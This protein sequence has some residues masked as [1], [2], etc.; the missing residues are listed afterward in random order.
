MKFKATLDRYLAKVYIKNMLAL[1]A[2]LLGIVYLFDTV[3]LLRRA[4]K[5]DDVSLGLVLQMGLFKLPEIWHVL[6]PFAILFS[7]MFTFWTL[8]KKYEL[9][10][11]RAA[12]FSVWQFLRP[13]MAVAVLFGVLQI[14]AINPLGALFVERFE[15]MESRYINRA[16]SEVAVFS[17]G[18]WLRQFY[19]L[20][21]EEQAETNADDVSGYVILNASRIRQKD[22]QLEGVSVFYFDGNDQFI[23]RVIA[24]SAKLTNGQWVFKDATVFKDGG[25]QIDTGDIILPTLLS[26]KDVEDSF[27]SPESLSF[28]ALPG[29]IKTLEATGFDSSQ[30]KVYY[31]TL[32]AQPLLF[33]SMILLAASVSMRL[34]RFQGTFK[35]ISIG[36]FIGFVIFFISSFLQALGASQQIPVILAA[37]SPATITFLVGVSVL[38]GQEDG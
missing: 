14:V 17:E 13:I 31:H 7:A 4:S 1:T 16:Q 29:H 5:Y 21:P 24:G 34:P 35:I 6:F 9:I 8:T 36:I 28:W 37:W 38:M 20:T 11:I 3:E 12:G 2:G 23:K 30:L 32:L 25:Y 26:I 27:S 18:L 22:W 19:T 33:V 10:I 15:H